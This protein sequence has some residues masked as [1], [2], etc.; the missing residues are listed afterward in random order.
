MQSEG[1]LTSFRS[2]EHPSELILM[3]T[4]GIQKGVLIATLIASS[5]FVILLFDYIPLYLLSLWVLAQLTLSVV[6]VNLARRLEK[7]ANQ[8][9]QCLF[10]KSWH[11]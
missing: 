4:K 2:F 10:E 7:F 11:C 8:N 1:V 3:M 6:R 9:D 5:L